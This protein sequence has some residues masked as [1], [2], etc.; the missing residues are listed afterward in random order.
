MFYSNLIEQALISINE[1]DFHRIGDNYLKHHFGGTLCDLGKKPAYSKTKPGKP[2]AYISING[3]FIIAEYTTL[4]PGGKKKYRD[5]LKQ[6]LASLLNESDHKIPMDKIRKVVLL[7]NSDVKGDLYAELYQMAKDVGKPLEIIGLSDLTIWLNGTGRTLASELLHIPFDIGQVISL[8]KFIDTYCRKR[9]TSPIKN[10]FFGRQE[11]I[12]EIMPLLEKHDLVFI[13]GSPGIGKTKLGLHLCQEFCKSNPDFAA[14]A[15]T[16]RPEEVYSSMKLQ[17]PAGKKF[18]ILVDDGH[19]QISSLL[20]ALN[21]REQNPEVL[22]RLLVTTRHYA[23]D[24]IIERL[25]ARPFKRFRLQPLPKETMCQILAGPDYEI[26]DSAII[27]R[28]FRLS[29]EKNMRFAIILAMVVK[30]NPNFALENS[31][32]VYESFFQEFYHDTHIF[33]DD[34]TVKV[35]GAMS[36]FETLDITRS[37]ETNMLYLLNIG[38]EEFRQRCQELEQFEFLE[39]RFQDVYKFPDQD[40]RAYFFYKAFFD[41]RILSFETLLTQTLPQYYSQMQ[42]NIESACEAMG[43]DMVMGKIENI[44][45]AHIRKLS[46]ED[47]LYAKYMRVFGRFYPSKCIAY[48]LHLIEQFKHPDDQYI[49]AAIQVKQITSLLA[50]LLRGNVNDDFKLAISVLEKI[51][52]KDPSQRTYLAELLQK[53]VALTV[54]DLHINFLR[55]HYLLQRAEQTFKEKNPPVFL[56]DANYVINIFPSYISDF[57]EGTSD[58]TIKTPVATLRQRFWQHLYDH[59]PTHRDLCVS[60]LFEYIG[61]FSQRYIASEYLLRFDYSHITAVMKSFFDPN[62]FEDTFFAKEYFT[63]FRKVNPTDQALRDRFKTSKIKLYKILNFHPEDYPHINSN[64]MHTKEEGVLWTDH[65]KKEFDLYNPTLFSKLYPNILEIVQC[66]YRKEFRFSEGV[67]QLILNIFK[68][69]TENGFNALKVYFQGGG[70]PYFYPGELL[71]WIMS[72]DE[73]MIHR[74][75]QL[76]EQHDYISKELWVNFFLEQLPS[77]S[78]LAQHYYSALIN[79]LSKASKVFLLSANKLEKFKEADQNIH[80]SALAILTSRRQEDN[81]FEYVTCHLYFVSIADKLPDILPLAQTAYLQSCDINDRFDFNGEDLLILINLNNNFL[82]EYIQHGHSQ[83]KVFRN[84]S[85][86]GIWKLPNAKPLMKSAMNYLKDQS[87]ELFDHRTSA[88]LFQLDGEHTSLVLELLEEYMIENIESSQKINLVLETMRN[89]F[90][91]EYPEIIRRL[92]QGRPAIEVFKKLRWYNSYHTANTRDHNWS[93][94]RQRI[95]MRIKEEI[96][97]IEDPII[98]FPY[99]NYLNESIEQ[100]GIFALAEAKHNYRSMY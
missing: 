95:L 18:I 16:Q 81:K 64:K 88:F 75:Y 29:Q 66:K 30:K 11:D 61:D 62:R 51:Y 86:K 58:V 50:P 39:S 72:N 96:F 23:L 14:F 89:S 60:I 85:L 91:V 53:E 4:Q 82:M 63:Y 35:L 54:N 41:K 32:K 8:D 69:K 33:K 7:C 76:I 87:Q 70:E 19:M 12:D 71:Q 34:L 74:C 93:A 79:Y 78:N 49:F 77:K 92:V 26:K 44:V 97:K 43:D 6:D 21:F 83:R 94:A 42:E 48:A 59:F 52:A 38:L 45:L 22:I 56:W 10:Q 20:E 57:F 40:L 17:L 90:E 73:A 37:E 65:F 13:E 100:E 55:Q 9:P 28:I 27:E 24:K 80:Q 15:I 5:K 25:E 99:I 84:R 31:V 46:Q 2:D 1:A 36:Y 68:Q 3:E 98:T 67:G 47:E